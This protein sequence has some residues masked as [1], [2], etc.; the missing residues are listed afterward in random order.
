MSSPTPKTVLIVGSGVFGLS[1]AYTLTQLPS[2][3]NSQITVVDRCPF[4]A[5][6]GSSIDTSRIIRAGKHF[7]SFPF[8]LGRTTN[9]IAVQLNSEA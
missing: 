3:S 4:P 8:L 5:P 1:T 6:D 9:T 2:F 7:P